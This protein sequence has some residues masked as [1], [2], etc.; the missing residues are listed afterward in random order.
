MWKGQARSLLLLLPTPGKGCSCNN[1]MPMD[2]AWRKVRSSV[3][4]GTGPTCRAMPSLP[5]ASSKRLFPLLDPI[6]GKPHSCQDVRQRCKGQKGAECF[7]AAQ[8]GEHHPTQPGG[9]WLEPGRAGVGFQP[10][11][12]GALSALLP[13]RV[14]ERHRQ[15]FPK[16]LRCHQSTHTC[17]LP[18]IFGCLEADQELVAVALPVT[19][20]SSQPPTLTDRTF[21]RLIQELPHALA[22]DAFKAISLGAASMKPPAA[23]LVGPRASWDS[24]RSHCSGDRNEEQRLPG[25]FPA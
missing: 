2:P 16:H 21:P 6:S 15:T 13:F 23:L 9:F 22:L 24:H 11:H 7:C 20:E 1:W 3:G 18:S 17:F 8:A 10:P 12:W 25:T 5:R 19:P 4:T 14:G